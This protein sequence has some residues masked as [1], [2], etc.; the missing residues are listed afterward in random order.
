MKHIWI[1]GCPR[2][3]TTFITKYIGNYVSE[4]FN[5]PFDLYP[6]RKV[7]DWKFPKVKSIVFKY[8]VNWKDANKINKKFKNSYFVHMSRDPRNVIYSMVFPKKD[9]WPYRNFYNHRPTVKEKFEDA[10]KRWF[11]DLN[12]CNNLS[13]NKNIKYIK[14]KYENLK[15]DMPKLSNFLNIKFDKNISFVNRNMD[16][17]ELKVL[18]DLWKVVD[19]KYIKL[20]K[21]EMGLFL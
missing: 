6:V 7:E 17:K 9:S 20:M 10:I 14:I 8:C 16:E 11:D 13:N 3:G 2:S 21:K 19:K 12:G 15:E 18:D 5:E 4:C 1:I